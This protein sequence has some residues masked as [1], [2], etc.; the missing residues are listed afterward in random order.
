[1]AT[2]LCALMTAPAAQTADKD[3]EKPVR[4]EAPGEVHAPSPDP[5]IRAW[6]DLTYDQKP[7][8]PIPDKDYGYNPETGAFTHPKATPLVK[9][10]PSFTGQ[11]TY[12]DQNSYTKNVTVLGFYNEVMSAGH[13]WQNIVDFNGRRY[14]YVSGGRNLGVYDITDPR[15]VKLV[16]L[17]GTH[18]V[19]EGR[20]KEP[21]VNPYAE[22]DMSGAMSI[23]WSKKLGKYVAVVSHAI[24]RYGIM[25]EK[26]L[27]PEGV[28]TLKHWKG[29]KG[30]QVFAVN[31]P[32][33]D[34]WELL[35]TRTTDVSHP[36]APNGQQQGSG[37]LDVPSWFGG[38][39]MFLSAAPDDRYMLT[40]FPDYLYSAGFQ[41]WD[42]SDPADPKFVSQFTA[43]GQI[44]GD[45]AHEEAYLMNPRAGN[46]TSWFG[47][48]MP[49]F[50]VKPL[51]KGGKY[52]FGSMASL[53]LY[54]LDL[55]DPKNMKPVGHVNTA[56][57]F[58]GTEFDNVDVSQYERTGYVF[59][60]GYPMNDECFEP[61]KD[62]WVVDAK[63]VKNPKIV[64]K[65][66]RPT[67]PDDAAFTDF[68]QRRGSFGPKRP[69]YH[70]TQPG[71]WRQGI[72]P[73]AFYNAGVQFF[74]V[75]NPL[76]VKIAGYFVP[77]F[78]KKGEAPSYSFGNLTYG[79]YAEYDRNI[80]W[81]FTNNGF[82]A[83]SSP[84]LGEP[85]FEA[86]KKPWPPKG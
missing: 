14:M 75:S 25:D 31:S 20:A 27:E 4:Y 46:R 74:D 49:P 79:I 3:E 73:Y 39:Y 10:A 21:E 7:P 43:P 40:E 62:I 37:S 72:I 82:Y 57:R 77:R 1:M 55:S 70:T 19:G 84:L 64:A 13:T 67:P 6:H 12:W 22:N 78:P 42:M 69:G 54:V 38:K 35:A 81:V 17:K 68:C 32:N 33:P 61:Y 24:P 47:S 71:K 44:L 76:D 48:R 5:D 41:A 56:P 16:H 66:P 58:A 18:V 15:N 28:K 30:F 85:L 11:L 2:A 50:L 80:V 8:R 86:P 26:L 36:D 63:D 45:P 51:E 53:G 83:V 23:Q 52:A 9:D 60:N 65:F 34:D 59:T 29:L